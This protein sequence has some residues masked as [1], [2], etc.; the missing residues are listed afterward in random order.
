MMIILFC[1]LCG[2]PVVGADFQFVRNG[3]PACVIVLPEHPSE[4]EQ[5]A[6][7]DMQ[8]F[9]RQMSGAEIRI[10]SEGTKSGSPS[11]YIGQTRFATQNGAD[12]GKLGDEEYQ[13][14]PAGRDLIVTGG[15]PIGSFYGVWK[16]LNRLGVWSLS[17]EQ[18]VVPK[19]QNASLNIKSERHAPTF[20]SRVIYDSLPIHY[21]A[22]KISPDSGLVLVSSVLG[23]HLVD[24]ETFETKDAKCENPV[25][26]GIGFS[27]DGKK[28]AAVCGGEIRFFSIPKFTAENKIG[29]E[30]RKA[31][32]IEFMRDSNIVAGFDK[33]ILSHIDTSS[34]SIIDFSGKFD[35]AARIA[36]SKEGFFVASTEENAS[37]KLWNAREHKL[38]LTIS[39][40]K[41]PECVFFEPEENLLGICD[42]E[43]LKFYPVDAPDLKLSSWELLRK[44][45]KEAGMELKDF[46]LEIP[47][48]K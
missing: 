26:Q 39:T 18:D 27:P 15:R 47:E 13:I 21:K 43:N 31:L 1:L 4:F 17:M 14:V 35:K 32:S 20:S 30:G 9:L 44:M 8:S 29:I 37:V 16:L 22:V 25:P 40:D 6:A 2:I 28:S 19:Q 36:V 5:Q 34:K 7:E 33:G 3:Q 23:L 45:E 42:G 48:S 41:K 24:L 38:M 12:F 11:V 46:Y 10:L